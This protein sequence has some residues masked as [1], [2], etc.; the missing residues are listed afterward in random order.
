MTNQCNVPIFM[1]YKRDWLLNYVNII[2]LFGILC[3]SP[4]FPEFIFYAP[5]TTEE[6]G[7]HNLFKTWK[8]FKIQWTEV[9]H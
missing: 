3:P 8:N 5:H 9:M 6:Q 1:A 7:E 2:C 4:S